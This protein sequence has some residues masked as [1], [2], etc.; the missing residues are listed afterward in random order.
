ME[1]DDF[2]RAAASSAARDPNAEGP[3]SSPMPPSADPTRT[4]PPCTVRVHPRARRVRLRIGGGGALVVTVPPGFSRRS[5][6]DL[7]DTH[8]AWIE[9]AQAEALARVAASGG[10]P[11]VLA[12]PA[13][14]ETWV[15]R[16]E[17]APGR[18]RLHVTGGVIVAGGPEE[19]WRPALRRFVA[20]RAGAHLPAW[21]ERLRAA[22]GL[23]AV[24]RVTIRHARTRWGSC[25][26]HGAISLSAALLFVP[27]ALAE[28]V[29]LHELAHRVRLDHSPAFWATLRRLD[30]AADDHRAALRH[31]GAL[32]PAWYAAG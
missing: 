32:V 23:P 27:P 24:A 15:V 29:L 25:S 22:H 10:W 2:G 1:R 6:P 12:L 4:L 21:V 8:R 9:R 13:V 30:P 20:Q 5:L 11:D 28:H 18:A 3:P 14:A 31:A 26:A 16:Y 17:P 7:L 19:A